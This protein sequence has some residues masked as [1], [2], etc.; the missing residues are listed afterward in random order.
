MQYQRLITLWRTV[1]RGW[2]WDQL[3]GQRPVLS[4]RWAGMR[5][6]VQAVGVEMSRIMTN[7]RNTEDT[8]SSN[9]VTQ[10]WPLGFWYRQLGGS[11]GINWG[12]KQGE[13]RCQVSFRASWSW[14]DSGKIHLVTRYYE[15]ARQK[16]PD[17]KVGFEQS[18]HKRE[19]SNDK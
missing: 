1:Q 12:N 9:L 7:I 19:Y 16:Q 8:N 11:S 18:Q 6:H 2:R 14:T 13:E 17:R 10:G 4:S 3:G 5:A 15:S